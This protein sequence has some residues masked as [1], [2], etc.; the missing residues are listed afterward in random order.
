MK[1]K[2]YLSILLLLLSCVRLWAQI[3][4]GDYS[5]DIESGSVWCGLTLTSNETYQITLDCNETE[6]IVYSAVLSLGHY[7]CEEERLI[8]HDDF[9]DY[10]MDL[11]II[12]NV[13][14]VNHGFIFLNNKSIEIYNQQ[15]SNIYPP[16]DDF[17]NRRKREIESFM[18][19]NNLPELLFR[20]YSDTNKLYSIKIGWFNCFQLYFQDVLILQGKWKQQGNMLLMYDKAL[21]HVFSLGIGNKGLVGIE[22]PGEFGGPFFTVSN[23]LQ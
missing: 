9:Y 11:S 17:L 3:N 13:I 7:T 20:I 10:D 2:K 14:S 18:D 15:P 5:I 4:P 23:T 21:G 1:S 6:D 22:I 16:S 12:D 8:L 19:N